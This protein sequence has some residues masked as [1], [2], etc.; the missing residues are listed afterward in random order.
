MLAAVRPGYELQCTSFDLNER[1]WGRGRKVREK[2]TGREKSTETG[3]VYEQYSEMS[4]SLSLSDV[5]E[6]PV[7]K[8]VRWSGI[9]GG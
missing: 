9:N 7:E 1:E 8:A 5:L 4:A 2:Q 6:P 3:R